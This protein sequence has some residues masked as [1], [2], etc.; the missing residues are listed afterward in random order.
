MATDKEIESKLDEMLAT[1]NDPKRNNSIIRSIIRTDYLTLLKENPS[2]LT[3]ENLQAKGNAVCN[4]LSNTF[5]TFLVTDPLDFS[6]VSPLTKQIET[7]DYY[8]S[9]GSDP[10]MSSGR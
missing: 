2:L 10:A 7:R 5:N 8:R 1:L 6:K 4:K 3:T 9:S